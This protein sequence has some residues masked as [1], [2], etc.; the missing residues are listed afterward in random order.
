MRGLLLESVYEEDN[1]SR[2]SSR[3]DSS[4]IMNASSRKDAAL[5]L[6]RTSGVML[7]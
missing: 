3:M 6:V 1:E 2:A 7:T 4:S 5:S